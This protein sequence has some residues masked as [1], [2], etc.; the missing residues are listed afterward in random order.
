MVRFGEPELPQLAKQLDG[1]SVMPASE[2][3]QATNGED[4]DR[5]QELSQLVRRTDIEASVC[6]VREV[7]DL[8]KHPLNGRRIPFVKHEGRDA[9]TS[10]RGCYSCELVPVFLAGVAD[11][12]QRRDLAAF[13]F[14]LSMF[15]H[16]SD[17]G[18]SS[19]AHHLLH[20]PRQE[21]RI[22]HPLRGPALPYAAVVDQLN[23]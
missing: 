2:R 15:E 10:K 20:H 21:L 14:A 6:P 18:F 11:E 17:L 22:A 4:R 12:H 5:A 7:G 1:A 3:G 13:A 23:F 8:A 9:S 16:P 19:A